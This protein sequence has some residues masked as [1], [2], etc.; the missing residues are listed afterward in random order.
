MPFLTIRKRTDTTTEGRT[1]TAGQRRFALGTRSVADL[2]APAAVEVARDHLRLD[3]QYARTLAVTGYPRS[4]AAGWLAPL[5]AFGTPLD[6]SFH[7]NPLETGEMLS[8][9]AHKLVQFHS[10]R[11]FNARSGRLADPERETAL[12]DVERLQ[13][14]LQKGVEHVFSVS[15]YLLLRATTPAALEE[16][17]HRVEATLAALMAHS[18]VA[19][20]EQDSGFRSCLPQGQDEL[21]VYRNLDTSSLATLFPFTSST[22]SM[23]RGLLYGIAAG[24]QAP[25]IVDPFDERLENANNAVFATSGAGKSY[26]TKLLALRSL[27]AGVDCL[28]LDPEDE[29]RTLCAAVDGQ[30][31]RLASTSPQRLNPFDLPKARDGGDR[32]ERDRDPLAEQVAALLGLFEVLLG[33]PGRP[34]TSFE[35][36]LLDQALYQTYAAAGITRDPA[37][38]TRPVPL[39][40]DLLHMLDAI[41]GDVALGLAARLRRYVDGSLAGLFSGPTNV[42]LDRRCVVFNLQGLEPELRPLGIHLI[43]SFVWRQV[44]R[45][46]RPRLLIIDEAWSLLQYPEGGA[47]LAG[48]ARRARK[49]YL[50][51]VT[52]TQDVADFLGSEHGRTVLG[53]AAMKLLLK[54][55]GATIGPV[56][57]AFS[58]SPEERQVLLGAGK[59][60]GLFFARGNRLRLQVEASPVEHRLATTAPR[61]LE[62]RVRTQQW[63]EETSESD[64]GDD[65]EM[66]DPRQGRLALPDPEEGASI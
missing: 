64:D 62:A 31:V 54:Q 57:A 7:I 17:T 5:L 26:F 51:L 10:S 65:D 41:P 46:R 63:Q 1:L 29:Y 66:V 18:R 4:V 24:S 3:G 60:E 12:D 52:I 49:Y 20:L 58:L 42:S 14:A 22:L 34:L 44:R 25:V 2:I 40:A 21:L 47:F 36:A 30:Q 16:L 61:E 6:L 35:R 8:A 59:G 55:D 27:L 53:N 28:V 33:E 15:F 11:L 56:T 48:M 19:V 45:S 13:D 37:T 9:L 38:H 32:D 43:T 23:E 50:G 39:L